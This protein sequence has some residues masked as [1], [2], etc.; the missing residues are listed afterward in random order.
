MDSL[1]RLE[2]G[3]SGHVETWKAA[4][5]AAKLEQLKARNDS[6]AEGLASSIRRLAKVE[7]SAQEAQLRTEMMEVCNREKSFP[8]LLWPAAVMTFACSVVAL[9]GTVKSCC[10]HEQ[11]HPVGGAVCS[12]NIIIVGDANHKLQY[13]RFCW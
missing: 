9:C 10:R 3:L 1:T 5:W 13:P 7:D 8:V 12:C 2:L 4:R 11:Y 6:L